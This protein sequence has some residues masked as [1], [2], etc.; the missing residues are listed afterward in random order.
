MTYDSAR[1]IRTTGR[2]REPSRRQPARRS[3]EPVH[4]RAG[5]RRHASR[6][7]KPHSVN[8][9]TTA[10][11]AAAAPPPAAYVPPEP[12]VLP[13]PTWPPSTA[14]SAAPRTCRRAAGRHEQRQRRGHVDGV[15]RRRSG[16]ALLGAAR[17]LAAVRD[18]VHAAR[19]SDRPAAARREPG[20]DIVDFVYTVTEPFVAPFRGMFQFDAV[21]PGDGSVFDFAALVALIG[22]PLIYLLIMA[23]LRLGDR[24]RSRTAY[25]QIVAVIARF[26][27]CRAVPSVRGALHERAGVRSDISRPRATDV[28]ATDARHACQCDSSTAHGGASSGPGSASSDVP[29]GARSAAL[30]RAARRVEPGRAEHTPA[31]ASSS[32]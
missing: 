27:L 26:C 12:V 17:P 10:R 2:T 16:S 19:P 23:I 25:G 9:R 32:S 3:R 11:A 8:P 31:R 20:N 30:E 1:G 7:T 29:L 14:P 24:S 13:A 22:W 4:R 28:G 18:P 21:A 15:R 6:S 5:A